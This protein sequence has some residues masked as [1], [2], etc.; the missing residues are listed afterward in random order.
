MEAL[1]KKERIKSSLAH[2]G[3]LAIKRDCGIPD[4]QP[5]AVSVGEYRKILKDSKSTDEQIE[6][7][8]VY[9]EALCRN[10]I[11]QELNRYDKS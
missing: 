10:V 2:Q 8:L 1:S 7:R 5:L 9:L 3:D 11:R 4:K 6:R